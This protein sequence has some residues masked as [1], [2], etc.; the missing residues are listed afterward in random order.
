MKLFFSNIFAAFVI[1]LLNSALC[2]AQEV[3][4]I[5]FEELPEQMRVE[6]RPVLI[7][8]YTD[9]CKFCALQKN[10][11]FTN[12]SIVNTLNE[13]YYCLRLNGE[14]KKEIA[15]LNRTY[16]FKATGTNTGQH[17]LATL[18]GK[19]DGQLSYP[20][21]VILSE[22]NQLLE[23]VSGFLDVDQLQELINHKER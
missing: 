6:R 12:T 7:F 11:T 4:W 1:I 13:N 10:N 2:D 18:L 3:K 19:Q 21:T 15:F 16:Q 14:S 5:A 20:T 22:N 8:L 23:R 9:W 17:E